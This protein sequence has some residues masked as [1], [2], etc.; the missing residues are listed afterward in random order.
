MVDVSGYLST[1]FVKVSDL[2]GGSRRCVISEIEIGK[3]ERP[4]VRFQDDTALGLNVTNLRTLSNAW[5]PE[6]DGWIGREVE[7]FV[8][9]LKYNGAENDA[10]LVRP[11]SPA[12]PRTVAVDMNDEIPF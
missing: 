7:L 5:G 2:A 11:I 12:V 1:H 4:D 6:T 3:F 9:K 8:G 10:V